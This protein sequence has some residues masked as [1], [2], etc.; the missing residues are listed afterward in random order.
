MS[1]G[2]LTGRANA[3]LIASSLAIAIAACIFLPN[4]SGAE[5]SSFAERESVCSNWLTYI[6]HEQGDWAGETTPR[7]TGAFDIAVD[8]V[9]LAT[10]FSIDPKGHVVVPVMKELPPIKISSQTCALDAD[11]PAGPALLIREVLRNRADL[12]IDTYGSLEAVQPTTDDAMFGHE[13]RAL[14]DRFSVDPP[15]FSARLDRLASVPLTEVGPLLTSKWH[16]GPP[17][18]NYC[19]PGDGGTCVVGCVATAAAQIMRYH[20]WPPKGISGH[21]YYWYGDYSCGG[22]TDSDWL[23]ADF[24]D[25]YDWENMEDDCLDGCTAEQEA[26]VAELCYEV[27]IAFEMFYG[28]CGSGTTPDM[29]L[30]AFP[31]FFRYDPAIDEELRGSHSQESWFSIIQEEINYGR[32]IL[33][34][35]LFGPTSGH[36]IV[37]DGWRD[38]GGEMQYHMN[39]GWG[40]G[41]DAWYAI[42]D[43]YHNYNPLQDVM[44][45]R[46]IPGTGFVFSVRP[47]GSGFYPTIQAAIDD[48][49]DLDIVELADGIYLGT[50]N[51]DIDFHGRPVTVRSESGDPRTCI[52]DCEGNPDEHRGFSFVSGEGPESVL[53]GITIAN[54]YALDGG[55]AIMC[56]SGSSPTIH[57]C[58]IIGSESPSG[59]GGILCTAAS[60][61][62]TGCVFSTNTSA[63]YGGAM[64]IDNFA[65]PV[66][67]NCT[68]FRNSASENGGGALWISSDSAVDVTNSMIVFGTG[69]GAIRCEGGSPI[70]AL[71]CCDIY[72]NV[73]GDWVGCIAGL[74]GIN[75]NISADP[76]FCDSENGNFRLQSESPCRPEANPS[77]G[78]IGALPPGCALHT[79]T[80]YGTGDYPTIQDAIDVASE[81]DAIELTDGIYTGIGNRDLDFGGKAIT[82]RSRNGDPDLCVID[83]QGGPGD[84]HRAFRFRSGEGP[85]SLVQGITIAGGYV[86]VHSGGGVW[87]SDGS[88]PTFEHCILRDNHA[89]ASGGAVYCSSGSDPTFGYCT[90]YNNSA[91]NG[92]AILCYG[93]EPSIEN[94]TFAHNSAE[95]HG[96]GV[97]IHS[98]SVMVRN[99]IVAFSTS[100]EGVY[101]FSGSL[102][103]E[104]C[105]VYGNLDG[106]WVGCVAGQAGQDGNISEN[107]LFCHPETGNY[108]LTDLSPCLPYSPPND[109]CDLVGAWPAECQVEGIADDGAA[110]ETLH[111]AVCA[112]NPFHHTTT[113][114][115]FIPE[116]SGLE[117]TRL[118]IFD[119]AGRAV[120]TL[121][122][123]ALAPGLHSIAWDGRNDRGD[124]VAAGVYLSRIKLGHEE[125]TRQIILLR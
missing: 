103:L 13:H 35:F 122:A 9:V 70:A 116:C 55:G 22:S 65:Q 112:P 71:E 31:T 68:F 50:G 59:G 78:L 42:D 77:C 18:N 94:C 110:P 21:S 98:G 26:A 19:P 5:T 123:S 56:A 44:Y 79:V 81:G 40:G 43:I 121:V 27:G 91:E 96:A 80:P 52:I 1:D 32:P 101:C 104:C 114:S 53:E 16:Q 100:G 88:S 6:V 14:W 61:A 10:C 46:I 76:L 87:C 117:L 83:C 28:R 62:L 85:L 30:H 72:G 11:A 54:G 90:F 69:G 36:S 7:I 108:R 93:S 39:Y 73:G 51:R 107:P 75:G 33:Y 113:I 109:L 45:R 119:P 102:T 2:R 115:F 66:I 4:V 41:Y 125:H 38:A 82:I 48:V 86:D 97:G 37:C 58:T 17:Y 63:L 34:G 99:T 47:D 106:D 105:D 8:G 29:A 24:D 20:E 60:P 111:L 67:T 120:R 74:E 49:L 25:P 95:S 92:G 3:G 64:M 12:F 23:W 118:I 15:A 84:D 124:A 89:G 57:N